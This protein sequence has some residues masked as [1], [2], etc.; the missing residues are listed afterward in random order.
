MKYGR[1]PRVA[2]ILEWIEDQVFSGIVHAPTRAASSVA[3]PGVRTRVD[4]RDLVE[5][6]GE[7]SVEL[8]EPPD[9]DYSTM[10]QSSAS[11]HR[12]LHQ[13]A[14]DVVPAPRYAPPPESTST[15]GVPAPAPRI[16][17]PR[18]GVPSPMPAPFPHDT[19]EASQAL[20]VSAPPTSSQVSYH[21][22]GPMVPLP[23][24]S[25]SGSR[26]RAIPI[27]AVSGRGL[28]RPPP[29]DDPTAATPTHEGRNSLDAAGADYVVVEPR[30]SAP[31]PH[32]RG[33]PYVGHANPPSQ[34]LLNPQHPST[35]PD[36]LASALGGI[37]LTHQGPANVYNE[38]LFGVTIPTTVDA[39]PLED[40]PGGAA[41]RRKARRG[42]KKNGPAGRQ[43]DAPVGD[44]GSTTADSPA[45]T[46][47]AMAR[48]T[49]ARSRAT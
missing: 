45:Q 36:V 20:P 24:S 39:G 40:A 5:L 12:H 32:P 33:N 44:L 9:H 4:P 2:A 29:T 30:A 6:D 37:N 17:A 16:S 15:P 10:P 41:T 21:G 7:L 35:T 23:V 22:D 34:Q 13:P 42:R 11:N 48:A 25:S 26:V 47:P 19:H 18:A 31:H 43:E 38:E 46:G 3:A 28:V 8:E 1:K 27:S 49:R 14:P